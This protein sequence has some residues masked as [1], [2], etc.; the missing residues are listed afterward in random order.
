[1]KFGITK[2]I[3]LAT[4]LLSAAAVHSQI[5]ISKVA[6]GTRTAVKSG[7]KI[8]IRIGAEEMAL[9]NIVVDLDIAAF[10]K[11][12]KYDLVGVYYMWQGAI[13]SYY[14]HEFDSPLNLKKYGGKGVI[15]VYLYNTKNF[16][17]TDYRILA[18]GTYYSGPDGE[19]TREIVV[20]GYYITGEEGYFDQ[21]DV[22]KTRNTYSSGE[23]LTKAPFNA[24]FSPEVMAEHDLRMARATASKLSDNFGNDVKGN[25]S[26][27]VAP[28]VNT[29]LYGALVDGFQEVWDAKVA[30]VM[31]ESDAQKAAAAVEQLT[32]DFALMKAISQKDKA[33][34]KTMNKEIKTKTTTDEKWELIK[35][36]A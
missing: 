22:Y 11:A 26:Q 17:E 1:M 30:A 10:K 21:Y 33:V 23:P 24:V 16:K 34:L 27:Y 4:F 29:P 13:I 6:N 2:S 5:K 12:Y 32:K 14:E 18:D 15:P 31:A 3:A 20:K 36:N 7:E 19:K 8:D 25:V 35:A 9:D 28:Y